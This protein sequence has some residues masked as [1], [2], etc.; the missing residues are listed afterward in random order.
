MGSTHETV[1]CKGCGARITIRKLEWAG[2][3]KT[4]S[5]NENFN[6]DVPCEGC[7][8]IYSYGPDDITPRFCP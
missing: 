1:I 7:E 3:R 2:D 8:E 5:R 6:A 4:Y